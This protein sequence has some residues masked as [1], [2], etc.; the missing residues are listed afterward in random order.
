MCGAAHA[1]GDLGNSEKPAIYGAQRRIISLS[2]RL[3]RGKIDRRPTRR[4]AQ[5]MRAAYH[6]VFADAHAL[7]NL[8]RGKACS[9]IGGKL[10]V[11]LGRPG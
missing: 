3:R 11:A 9:P 5:P 2:P 6:A 10:R 8:R 7:A 1:G 4:Q